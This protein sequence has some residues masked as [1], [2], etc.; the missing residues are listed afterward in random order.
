MSQI[1]H[2]TSTTSRRRLLSLVALLL[3]G[4]PVM[5]AQDQ[6]VDY[7]AELPKAPPA[8]ESGYFTPPPH[9]DYPK[10]PFGEAV[11]RGERLF[12]DTRHAA[13]DYVGNDQNCVNCHIDAGRQP[14]A[15]PLWAAWVAYPAYRKKNDHVNTMEERIRGCFTYSM[16]AKGS[17]VGH[18]PEP[19]NPLLTDLQAYM[20]WLASGAPTGRKL[21][22]RGYPKLAKPPEPYSPERGAKVYADNCAICHGDHGQGTQLAD[23]NYAFPPLWGKGAFNWGAGMHRVNTAAGFIKANM[24]LG[25]PDSLSLQDAWDV[26]AFINHHPRPSDP[27]DQGDLAATDAK[28]HGH[29]CYYGDK[30]ADGK[31]LGTGTGN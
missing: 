15:A 13:A 3:A 20:Y 14:D 29:A 10:G 24:P 26:A 12:N 11:K 7:Q 17:K 16:N 31:T 21:P 30:G 25:K 23:G 27:R 5:A 18:A 1:K 28:F 4:P 2:T 6:R 8:G 19:G 9:G 22:G